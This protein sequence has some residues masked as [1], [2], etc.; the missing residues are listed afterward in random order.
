[1][2]PAADSYLGPVDRPTDLQTSMPPTCLT[3]SVLGSVGL[4]REI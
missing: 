2:L 4:E 1:M 3:W